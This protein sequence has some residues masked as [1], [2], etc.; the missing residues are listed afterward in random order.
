MT[1]D[2]KFRSGKGSVSKSRRNKSKNIKRGL[3]GKL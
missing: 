2:G 3:D 1:L